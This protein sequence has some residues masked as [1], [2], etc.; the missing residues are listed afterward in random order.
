MAD[1]KPDGMPGW[2]LGGVR[3]H[4][5]RL[6]AACKTPGCGQFVV[7]DLDR[8][9]AQLGDDYPLPESGPGMTC[10]HCGGE[11]KFQL[12]VWHSDHDETEE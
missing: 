6:E 3:K 5:M 9:I 1:E 10:E 7:F 2:T 12:A 11:M 8:L 4:G